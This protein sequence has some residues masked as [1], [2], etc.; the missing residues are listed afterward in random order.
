MRRD[1]HHGHAQRDHC[2]REIESLEEFDR[3]LAAGSLAGH[4]VQSVDLT[5]RTFAL[6][7][8]DTVGRPS[9]SAARWRRR[10]PPRY[11]PGARWSSRPSRTCPS[12]RT[13]A[14]STPRT[15]SSRGS[16]TAGYE[17]TPDARAYAW[18]QQTKADGDIFASM[19]RAHPRRRRLRRPGRTPRRRP[20]GGR[21]GRPR[22]GARR[23]RRTRAPPGSAAG[24]PAAGLTVATGGGPGAMEAANLGAYAAPFE[25]GMLD[26]ALR[27]PRRGAAFTPVDHR[28]G[29]GRLRACGERLAGRRRL[30]RHPDLVLRARAAERLRRRTSPSTS[31]TRSART[32]CWPAPPRAWS[33]CR[34]PPGPY[35]RSSTTRRPTTTGRAASRRRWCWSTAPTGPSTLPTWPLLQALAAGPADGGPDRAG[36]LGGRGPRGTRPVDRLRG[37]P[38]ACPLQ[39]AASRLTS[40]SKKASQ[41]SSA[42]AYCSGVRLPAC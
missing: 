26:E 38:G 42:A 39:T 27:T 35:R 20:G 23:P 41:P 37:A 24:W 6:L 14:G 18:F 5:D 32:G 31:P 21:D 1:A 9:S 2:D 33:S 7:G 40:A 15:S 3:V 30:G 10:P 25:D 36:R 17:A 8:A 22:A 19:L 12:T 34:A 4:R 28:L 16:P 29:A 11:A 13:A